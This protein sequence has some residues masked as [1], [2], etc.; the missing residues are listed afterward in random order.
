MEKIWEFFENMNEMVYVA[1]LETHEFIYMNK[2][3]RAQFQMGSVEELAG[4]KCYQVL[5]SSNAPCAFC[6]SEKIQEGSFVE[7]QY[8][9]PIMNRSYALKDT[10]VM[11]QGRRCRMEIAIDNTVREQ[12]IRHQKQEALANEG[13]S[14]ALRADSPD[15]SLD[16][17][18]EYLGKSL[19]GER[20][21]IFEKNESGGDDNTYE[22]VADGVTPE[23]DNLQNVP[24]EVCA[25]WYRMF[26]EHKSILIENIENIR[27]YEPRQYE[28]LK[29]QSIHSLVV[30]PL[31]NDT[32][33]IGFF[34]VD[35]P[36]G[37]SLEFTQNMLEIVGHF[38]VSCLKRRD[39]LN[40]LHEMSYHD[41][42]TKLGN[43]FAMDKYMENCPDEESL[44]VVYCDITGL[45]R[46]ND[47]Q[48]HMAGDELILRACNSL[49]K[50]FSEYGLFRIG[51]DEL[52]ALCP[53][54]KEKELE[55][56][57]KLL[58]ETAMA[59]SVVLAVGAVWQETAKGNFDKL[60][61]RADQ[62]MYED[63]SAYYKKAGL[64]RRRN[65]ID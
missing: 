43:R 40:E 6:N 8:F 14:L 34:G 45:K 25:S 61:S 31:H 51:G 24:P 44:G 55:R 7:W 33:I 21:Y 23:I 20:T 59:D 62:L 30:V 53:G 49:K 18:L 5:Q 32:N 35:N 52:L 15:K 63:K 48:G 50:V 36:R 60:L 22:W 38:I 17:L 13:M 11:Y 26:R 46:T 10:L 4:K 27:E 47:S 19:S 58:K 42:L 39:L 54:I 29:Q 57:A 16:I 41:Q 37:E 28:I 9:N 12:L 56:R 65:S 1:D 64:E 2:K 3:A